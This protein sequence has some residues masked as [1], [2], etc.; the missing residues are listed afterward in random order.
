MDS[1]SQAYPI[2]YLYLPDFKALKR[3]L[4]SVL[5]VYTTVILLRQKHTIF[6]IP[7]TP[8]LQPKTTPK[9]C[10]KLNCTRVRVELG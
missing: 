8:F 10:F 1:N 5:R 7:P 2:R 3:R 9:I 6:L 4:D